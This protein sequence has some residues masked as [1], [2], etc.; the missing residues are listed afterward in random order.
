MIAWSAELKEIENLYK[1]LKGQLPDLEKELSQLFKSDDPNV[2]MLYSRRCLEVII[3]D[4][5]ENE[6][7]RPRGTEPLKGIIDKLSHEEKVPS[8]IIAS[9]H[10]VNTLSTFGTHPK[11]FEPE[12]VKPVLNNLSTVLKWYLKYIDFQHVSKTKAEGEKG[13]ENIPEKVTKS[14]TT[15]PR[16]ILIL[17]SAGLFLAAVVILAL[18]KLNIIGSKVEK[19]IAI[20]PFRND[21]HEDSTTYFINGV[22]EEILNNLQAIKDLR[23]ISRSS[24]EQYRNQIK[25]VPKIAKELGVNFIVEGSG[26]K[27]GK[28][29]RLRVQLIKAAK[30]KHLW[31]NSYEQEMPQVKYYF[32]LQNQIAQR[33]ANELNARISINEKQLI[34]KIPTENLE[35]Y[36]AYLK[37]EFYWRNLTQSDLQI[38]MKYFELAKGKDSKYALPYAGIS[39]VWIALQQMGLTSPA[40]AGPKAMEAIM[41]A[42][43][44]DSTLAQVHYSLA[45]VRYASEWD[46]KNGESE[47]LKTL[48]I[49]PNHAEARAYY[50]HLLNILGRSKEAM[51]QIDQALKLDPYSSLIKSMYAFD[52]LFVHQNDKAYTASLEALKMD[53]NNPVALSGLIWSLY[54]MG[55]YE[56]LLEPCKSYYYDTYKEIVHAFDQ[57]YA[58]AG[59]AG[60]FSLEAD[61][62][63]AQ[64]RITFVMPMD[65]SALYL[66]AGKKEMALEWMEKGYEEHDPTMPYLLLPVYDSL[67]NEP[68]FQELARKMNLPF[69]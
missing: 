7:K 66:F 60:A 69:K 65:I 21:S 30:E 58:K 27:Y 47:F 32:Q 35:A 57:G 24:V 29:L 10:G 26:Q 49:N 45:L 36:D 9:M 64:S 38:A 43:E 40:E 42:I 59:Y 2:L 3:T 67:R 68:R 63:A 14:I 44:L 55:R 18:I 16:K 17:L 11:D 23:V 15:K 19:S 53:P 62:L 5:C 6:L 4:L 20:L 31:G 46:W 48:A 52:L 13:F 56:E 33:I 25:S 54:Q 41:K 34:E 51:E 39:D 1:S 37:G 8:Y 22:M 61:S 28:T 12:Q 50:S